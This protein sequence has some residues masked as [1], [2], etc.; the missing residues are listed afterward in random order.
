MET[1]AIDIDL[2]PE[3]FV[4][5]IALLGGKDLKRTGF[6]T[7]VRFV[8]DKRYIT[9]PG[10]DEDRFEILDKAAYRGAEVDIYGR[11]T[12]CWDAV[13]RS[14]GK[15]VFIK[16]AWR[17]SKWI[18]EGSCLKAAMG[19]EGVNQ[20]VASHDFSAEEGGST[21]AFRGKFSPQK[22]DPHFPFATYDFAFSRLVLVK[23][24]KVIW[25]F[26]TRVQM[27][28]VYRGS[29]V[30]GYHHYLINQLLTSS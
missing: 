5:Y 26:E 12:R 24:G 19:V 16:D 23:E 9:M 11:G 20:A 6:D 22:S 30:G 7:S 28:K 17:W 25:D 29:I 2:E 18:W 10:G 15:A 1:K 27:L 8:G 14:T 4:M 13:D 3:L 21:A